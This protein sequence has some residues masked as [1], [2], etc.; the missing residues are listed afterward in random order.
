MGVSYHGRTYEEGK[1][2]G[3]KD[4]IR[5]L[6]CVVRYNMPHAPLPVQFIG[7]LGVGGICAIANV[8]L[9]GLLSAPLSYAAAAPI[10][11]T[12]AAILNYWLCVTILFRRR[13]ANERWAEIVSYITVVVG[14]G[15]LDAISTIGMIHA[16]AAPLVAKG[17]ASAVALS[18]NF[19]GRRFI[20]FPEEPAGPWAPSRPEKAIAAAEEP[21]GTVVTTELA[22]SRGGRAADSVTS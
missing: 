7:Y 18:F 20:V 2:I 9:F 12:G 14:A 3:A 15:V 13:V 10:A 22:E 16:G 1:K 8:L 6:Y 17:I 4:G 5:A 19:T 21:P 11:F